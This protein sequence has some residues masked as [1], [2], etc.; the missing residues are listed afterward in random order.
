[1]IRLF[2]LIILTASLNNLSAQTITW[3]HPDNSWVYT[4]V[5][6]G[7]PR[8]SFLELSVDRDTTIGDLKCV[9]LRPDT[10]EIYYPEIVIYPSDTSRQLFR[11]VEGEFT[12]LYDFDLPQGATY[13]IKI[14]ESDFG[15]SGFLTVTVDSVWTENFN[16]YEFAAQRLSSSLLVGGTSYA[17]DG[18]AYEHIG[19]VDLYFIPIPVL[20]CD[21][22]C[23]SGQRCFF[24]PDDGVSIQL[25]D[26]PC[27]RV[28]VDNTAD[29]SEQTLLFPNPVGSNEQL[30]F[31]LTSELA[32]RS[33]EVRVID[34]L[35][36][37][38]LHRPLTIGDTEVSFN[39]PGLSNGLYYLEW[40]TGTSRALRRFVVQ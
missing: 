40:R 11:Y 21:A 12:V 14:P 33:A 29:V 6:G 34:Q 19:M 38:V 35:G 16:G 23:P 26:T 1:M 8:T 37:I 7:N 27:F 24:S 4:L 18:V 15:D 5:L 13:D 36:R 17:F 25:G 31:R 10:F 2:L 20:M 22:A 30:T 3:D 32:A 28:G 9:I 39:L